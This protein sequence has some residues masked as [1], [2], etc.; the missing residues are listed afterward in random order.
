LTSAVD[1]YSAFM[2]LPEREAIVKCGPTL[3]VFCRNI[4]SYMLLL[5][6]AVSDN[7]Q[8]YWRRTGVN[9]TSAQH[10]FI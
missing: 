4:G 1:A 2:M 3:V 10:R 8:S 6:S 5:S 7:L 9:V